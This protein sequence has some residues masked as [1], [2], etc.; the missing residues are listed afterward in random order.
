MSWNSISGDKASPRLY[1]LLKSNR[2]ISLGALVMHCA[3]CLSTCTKKLHYKLNP[4]ILFL[5]VVKACE[6]DL[7]FW[8]K[9]ER[10]KRQSTYFVLQQ[11]LILAYISCARS[12]ES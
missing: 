9:L 10:L 7:R 4:L 8:V 6:D 11:S 3:V 2:N 12:S 1:V 5:K